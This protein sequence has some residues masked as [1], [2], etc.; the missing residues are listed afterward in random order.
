M[1]IQETHLKGNGVFRINGYS[2][3]P[4]F[5]HNRKTLHVRA[6]KR[7]GGVAVLCWNWILD[8]HNVSLV[9]KS[10]DGIM[11]VNLIHK[12]TSYH[13]LIVGCYLPPENSLY[14]RDALHFYSHILSYMYQ[15]HHCDAVYMCGDLNSKLGKSPDVIPGID[16]LTKRKV[17]DCATNNHG[18]ALQEFLLYSKCCVLNGR[19]SPQYDD[20][21]FIEPSREN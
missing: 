19:V 20:Y 6:K 8:E 12:E 9:D 13:I 1:I 11:I 21:T 5:F 16:E 10:M 14:G 4:R 17:I 7:Y 2:T 3:D 18:N 15:Y